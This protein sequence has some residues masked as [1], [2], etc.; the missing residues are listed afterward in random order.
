[1]IGGSGRGLNG[2]SMSLLSLVLLVSFNSLVSFMFLQMMTIFYH[3][4]FSIKFTWL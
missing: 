1:M 4:S 2:L 3:L